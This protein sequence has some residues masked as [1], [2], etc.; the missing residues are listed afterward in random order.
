RVY[1]DELLAAILFCIQHAHQQNA[2]WSD[3]RTARLEQQMASERAED[4]GDGLCVI[5]RR[6]RLFVGIAHAESPAEIEIPQF[7]A[8]IGKLTE[9]TRQA[10]EGA[11]KGSEAQNLRADMSADPAPVDPTRIPVLQILRK[12]SFPI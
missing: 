3:D 8:G 2:G 7:D 10:R 4:A 9:M 11:A 6:K 1:N 12:R 5:G